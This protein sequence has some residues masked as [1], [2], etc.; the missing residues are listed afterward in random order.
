MNN[1]I[2]II[3]PYYKKKK[4]IIKTLSSIYSQSY[5]NFELIIIYDDQ[6]K[7]DFIFINNYIKSKRLKNVCIINNKKNIGVGLSRNLGV[8]K[9]RGKFIA[10][11]DADDYW[12]KNKLKYQINFMIKKKIDFSHT[13][14]FIVDELNKKIK[15]ININKKINHKQLLR[16]CDIGLSTVMIKKKIL[17]NFRFSPLKTKEDYVLWLK[18]SKKKI[19]LYGIQKHLTCWRETSNSLSSSILQKLINAFEVYNQYLKFNFIKSIFFT[20]ILSINAIKKRYL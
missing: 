11:I 18:L 10:F 1:L 5:K 9:S 8:N 15:E 16:S 14:Y 4:F 13:S 19:G 20:F 7:D 2:S 3:L 12:L 6:N 17:K